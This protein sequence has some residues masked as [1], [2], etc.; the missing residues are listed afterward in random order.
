VTW[1]LS[2]SSNSPPPPPT[3]H[4]ILPRKV[5]SLQTGSLSGLPTPLKGH[6]LFH[7]E[8]QRLVTDQ[9]LSDRRG[10]SPSLTE[11]SF[12]SFP[13]LM[14]PPSS[15]TVSLSPWKVIPFSHLTSLSSLVLTVEPFFLP[16][17]SLPFPCALS[18]LLA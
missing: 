18:L 7:F 1:F 5:L 3:H 13:C 4:P 6:F 16:N 9:R 10:L 2:F 15:L 8:F 14:N 11:E 17:L 12:D